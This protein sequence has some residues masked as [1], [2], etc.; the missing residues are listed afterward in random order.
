VKQNVRMNNC[1]LKILLSFL[2]FIQCAYSLFSQDR[3]IGK[4]VIHER[5]FDPVKL[6]KVAFYD[7]ND[8]V[9]CVATT[10]YLGI[11]KVNIDINTI[12]K[13]KVSHPLFG[14]SL[15]FEKGYDKINFNDTILVN[16]AFDYPITKRGEAVYYQDI[17]TFLSQKKS[18]RLDL[19]SKNLCSIPRLNELKKHGVEGLFLEGNNISTVPRKVFKIKGLAYLDLSGNKL[20]L[21][22]IQRIEYWQRKG[23][24]IIY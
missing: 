20:D 18:K 8:S 9:F 5:N 21:K 10:D 4:F 3:L 13:I 24:M 23:I 15:V 2:A 11:I 14:T 16:M 1:S 22:S 6:A 17:D 19:K 7:K 12:T